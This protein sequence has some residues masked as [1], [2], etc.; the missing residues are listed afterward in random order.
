MAKRIN[1][2]IP[3][4]SRKPL[5][6]VVICNFSVYVGVRILCKGRKHHSL[7]LPVD[8]KIPF[9]PF[10]VIFYILA[11]LQ[12]IC[13]YIRI[14][15]E[16]KPFCRLYTRADIIAKFLCGI[17]FWAFPTT[18]ARP[19][20]TGTGLFDRLTALIYRIDAP[21]NLFPSIHCLESW[22]CL[23]SAWQMK[24]TPS[25]YKSFS[26][27]LT[28]LVFAST[29][30]LKQHVFLDIPGGILVFETGLA[31]SRLAEKKDKSTV[32]G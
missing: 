18:I 12:W 27:I 11:Y 29:V 8:G 15:R 2:L 28:L 6:M 19:Q 31:L 17:I 16:S 7:R 9:L 20:I 10:F 14:A 25:W 4:Y 30:C 3:S 1:R 13:G 26:L 22:V 21:D 24:K 32:K 5:L 23:R